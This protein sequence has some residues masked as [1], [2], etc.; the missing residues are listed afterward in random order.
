[1]FEEE[2]Q[3]FPRGVRTSRIGEGA[4]R[5]APRP[6]V[7]GSMDFPMLKDCA[8]ARVRREVGGLLYRQG[9]RRAGAR[10]RLLRGDSQ[11]RSAA[12]A[13]L[14][15]RRMWFEYEAAPVGVDERVALAPVELLPRIVTAR[16]AGP[17][18][19]DTLAVDDRRR[20]AGFAPDPF[21]ICHHEGVLHPFKAPVVAPST[22]L[23]A[24]CAADGYARLNGLG[25]LSLEADAGVPADHSVSP[26]A[27]VLRLFVFRPGLLPGD[28]M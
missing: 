17:G 7:C 23:N 2:A 10:L 9:S 12:V 28:W 8:S 18:S 21:P 5:T 27:L 22:Q 20:G 15:A 11:K 25:A 16:A 3:H 6:R 4:G 13:I 19:L 1:M 26:W 24:C 14:D